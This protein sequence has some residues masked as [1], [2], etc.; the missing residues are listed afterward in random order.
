MNLQRI[1][2]LQIN[3]PPF[4]S[5]PFFNI[6]RCAHQKDLTEICG[7]SSG[8]NYCFDSFKLVCKCIINFYNESCFPKIKEMG[9]KAQ[10]AERNNLNGFERTSY[11]H[12]RG[13][14]KQQARVENCYSESFE[15]GLVRWP[16]RYNGVQFR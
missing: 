1:Q 13:C 7:S 6:L 11:K 9:N 3:K 16:L 10:Y 4:I 8:A 5:L 12:Q 2:N 15:D 14:C